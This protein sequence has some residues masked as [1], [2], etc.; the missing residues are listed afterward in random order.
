MESWYFEE[1]DWGNT[2]DVCIDNDPREAA[3]APVPGGFAGFSTAGEI[4]GNAALDKDLY[5]RISSCD[6]SCCLVGWDVTIVMYRI[7]CGI[8][9]QRY[10]I[11]FEVK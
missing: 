4:I 3:N 1:E 7:V 9:R 6:W 5:L 2:I 10:L 11:F 8:C